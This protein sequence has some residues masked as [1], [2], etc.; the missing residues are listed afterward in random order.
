LNMLHS[1]AQMPFDRTRH[2]VGGQRFGGYDMGP[3]TFGTWLLGF[4][5]PDVLAKLGNPPD[6]SKLAELLKDPKM[7]EEIQAALK[8]KGAPK[9]L[10]ANF[11]NP[12]SAQKFAEMA[13]KIVSGKG[14]I[15]AEDMKKMM[16]E[17]LQS[18]MALDTVHKYK[19]VGAKPNDIALAWSL[20]KTPDKLTAADKTS[21]QGKSIQAASN[22][23]YQL[24]YASRGARDGDEIRW[25]G[26]N[27]DPNSVAF[28]LVHNAAATMDG[29]AYGCVR[30]HQANMEK[31]FGFTPHGNAEDCFKDTW[32][33]LAPTGKFDLVKISDP[34]QFRAGDIFGVPWTSR[35][36][37]EMGW[38]VNAGHVGTIAS[39]GANGREY[40]Q[41]NFSNEMIFSGRYDVSQLY[42]I[43]A[44]SG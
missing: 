4:L 20:D 36:T 25:T 8:A 19:E 41:K 3:K 16:P 26:D 43:R 37:A 12:E 35:T 30:S 1:M 5:P 15:T 39:G 17:A 11:A 21:E 13:G 23:L 9:E 40:S 31:T 6:L 27:I 2:V 7:L 38:G 29:T 42:V 34:S 24:S 44:K 32:R 28:R 18:A 14:E 10:Q 33:H 22:R